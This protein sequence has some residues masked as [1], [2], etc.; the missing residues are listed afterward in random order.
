[1]VRVY[2][3]LEMLEFKCEKWAGGTYVVLVAILVVS[4]PYFPP[5]HVVE[6]SVFFEWLWS[7]MCIFDKYIIWHSMSNQIC[8]FVR[9]DEGFQNMCDISGKSLKVARDMK[10]RSW[11]VLLSCT[12]HG[13][14]T[15]YLFSYNQTLYFRHDCMDVP[16]GDYDLGWPGVHS[17]AYSVRGKPWHSPWCLIPVTVRCNEPL[18]RRCNSGSH[19]WRNE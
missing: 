19:S 1:M 8:H 14:Y 17:W 5:V 16:I 10:N 12:I 13:R 3:L 2:R 15:R 7:N 6:I 18:Y 11:P 9:I 4:L